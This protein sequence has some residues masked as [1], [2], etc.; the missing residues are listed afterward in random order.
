MFDF[1]FPTMKKAAKT[2]A[3]SYL[4]KITLL[5][6][7][8]AIWRQFIV[9][10]D[11]TLDRLH[12][13]IQPIMG[14]HDG[15]MHG[16]RIGDRYCMPDGFCDNGELPESKQVLSVIAPKKGSKFFYTYDFGDSWEHE[17][18]VE[19]TNYSNPDWPYPVCCIDGRMACPPDDCGGVPGYFDLCEAMKYKNH[20]NHDELVDWLGYL[21]IP[22]FWDMEEV[23]TAFKI[24]RKTRR[25]THIWVKVSNE[26]WPPKS[27]ETVT[28]TPKVRPNPFETKKKAAKKAAKKVVKK[29]TKKAV[30]KSVKKATK[31]TK[32]KS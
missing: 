14:W 27:K 13:I 8:P 12:E 6:I 29:T 5:G 15:H 25:P 2:N 11:T 3:P 4:L 30:K 17:I 18:V 21:Y 31:S 9:P 7:E 19:N 32:K 23:N 16:F 1:L 10:A 26:P 20:P 24:K 28:E 22:Y